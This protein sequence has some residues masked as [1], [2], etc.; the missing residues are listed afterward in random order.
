MALEK[1]ILHCL[2]DTEPSAFFGTDP[3]VPAYAV[4]LG[5]ECRTNLSRA[6]V[7]D[8]EAVAD[9]KRAELEEDEAAAEIRF[10]AFAH[11]T[12]TIRFH[13]FRAQIDP[14]DPAVCVLTED[15]GEITERISDRRD[16]AAGAHI[17]S[18]LKAAAPETGN[19]HYWAMPAEV[20]GPSSQDVVTVDADRVPATYRLRAAHAWNAPVAHRLS[21]THILRPD[22]APADPANPGLF[23]ILPFFVE[24]TGLPAAGRS[25]GKRWDFAYD[26]GGGLGE[27]LCRTDIIDRSV[28][29]TQTGAIGF[30]TPQ[31]YLAADADAGNLWRV[32]TWFEAR[33]ASL[34]A[35]GQALSGPGAGSDADKDYD[36]LFHWRYEDAEEPLLHA[37]GPAWL[38]A[39]SLCASLDNIVLGIKKPVSGASSAG[40][41]LGSLV[42]DLFDAL[43]GDIADRFGLADES[44]R[45]GNPCHGRQERFRKR[46]SAA[47]TILRPRRSGQEGPT[48]CST[49][50]YPRYCRLGCRAT[51]G[52]AAAGCLADG[53]L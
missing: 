3:T 21:L 22:F 39:I 18:W 35:P 20:P 14:L 46:Q 13:L 29:P 38:A 51:S 9:A 11:A 16:A 8:A 37:P 47:A 12:E 41:I 45:S 1:S 32:I 15:A 52:A 10:R 42:V 28:V 17:M 27:I 23:V 30:V 4:N 43:Q 26:P 19:R 34:M 44:H 48:C 5:F 33:A 31:G 53:F 6:D 40:D 50:P 24:P 2:L 25:N 49:P 7:I 36:A